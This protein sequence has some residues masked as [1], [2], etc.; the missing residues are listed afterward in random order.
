MGFLAKQRTKARTAAEQRAS[1]LSPEW[2]TEGMLQFAAVARAAACSLAA[3]KNLKSSSF[4]GNDAFGLGSAMRCSR[5]HRLMIALCRRARASPRRSARSR[6]AFAATATL[7]LAGC[8]GSSAPPPTSGAGGSGGTATQAGQTSQ[9]AF[10]PPGASTPQAA[11]LGFE[12]ATDNQDPSGVCQ[13]ITPHYL[14]EASHYVSAGAGASCTTIWSENFQKIGPPEVDPSTENPS[15]VSTTG[16]G[17]TVHVRINFGIPA[18]AVA[19]LDDST[20]PVE[21]IGGRWLVDAA[22]T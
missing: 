15:V 20:L 4:R 19:Q 11:A 6:L 1:A 17:S 9:P 5:R 16:S 2:G 13:Y 3:E 21:E 14:A 18:S 12:N 22:N 8:G 10:D 7:L